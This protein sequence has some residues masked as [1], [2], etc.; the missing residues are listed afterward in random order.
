MRLIV[1]TNDPF[2]GSLNHKNVEFF[3]DG[4]SGPFRVTSQAE[5]VTEIGSEQ[6]I[7]WN[8]ANTDN[9]NQ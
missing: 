3:V 5:P 4:E 8:V 7:T 9:P 2:G 6:T 1:R